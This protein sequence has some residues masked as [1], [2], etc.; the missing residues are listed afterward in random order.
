MFKRN[1]I[2]IEEYLKIKKEQIFE[3]LEERFFNN[4]RMLNIKI[5]SSQHASDEENQK[6]REQNSEF[7]KSQFGIST[8]KKVENLKTFKLELEQYARL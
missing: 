7:Y 8:I 6:T 5:Y 4:P 1:E 2:Y 3:F